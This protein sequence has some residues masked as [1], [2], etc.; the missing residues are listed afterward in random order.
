MPVSSK[1]E[2]L[3]GMAEVVTEGLGGHLR[4]QSPPETR[5]WVVLKEGYLLKVRGSMAFLGSSTRI[6]YFVLKQ[7]V[8]TLEARLEQYDGQNFRS[9]ITIS[10][11]KIKPTK[12]K[13]CFAVDTA[14]DTL[15]LRAENNDIKT[16]TDWILA[17]QQASSSIVAKGRR[18]TPPSVAVETDIAAP[19]RRI[20]SAIVE[21]DAEHVGSGNSSGLTSPSGS[22]PILSVKGAGAAAEEEEAA[23]TWEALAAMDSD[24]GAAE[25]VRLAIAKEQTRQ[26]TERRSFREKTRPAAATG[27]RPMSEMAI[28]EE[29]SAENQSAASSA[30][31]NNSNAAEGDGGGSSN[32]SSAN[33]SSSNLTANAGANAGAVPLSSDSKGKSKKPI[34]KT[35]FMENLSSKY[36]FVDDSF[37]EEPKK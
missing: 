23:R 6:R 13:G 1:A 5:D 35:S 7:N 4:V 11:A 31:N 17:L 34:M 22:Q 15:Q 18:I 32:S 9:S 2:Q 29:Q 37:A 14:K 19:D 16:A 24:A 36:R 33:T 3:L 26:E 10:S 28:S 12:S 20:P 30:A 27:T 21:E 25:R 8:D